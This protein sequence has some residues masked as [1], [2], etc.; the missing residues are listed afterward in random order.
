[1][2]TEPFT[3]TIA[4]TPHDLARVGTGDM[5]GVFRK[6][7]AGLKATISHFS[8]KRDRHVARFDFDKLVADTFTEG[9]NKNVSMS[10]QLSI[11]T[12]TVGF[13]VAE[14]EAN[15]QAAIDKLDSAGVLTKILNWES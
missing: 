9:I 10:V 11:D 2:F 8:G 12:P 14:V 1:M 7:S 3:V 5:K 13:T 6:T 15:V 4:A